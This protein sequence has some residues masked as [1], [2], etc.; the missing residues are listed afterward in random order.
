MD[1][2]QVVELPLLRE[3]RF[4]VLLQFLDFVRNL[5]KQN[6]DI[7]MDYQRNQGDLSVSMNIKWLTTELAL[8]NIA[9][10]IDL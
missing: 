5:S 1:G 9:F 8:L 2:L 4:D 3:K 6:D 7:E 10:N